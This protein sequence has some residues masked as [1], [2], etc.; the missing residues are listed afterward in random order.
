MAQSSK[1]NRYT[2]E[3]RRQMVERCVPGACLSYT[4]IRPKAEFS[5]EVHNLIYSHFAQRL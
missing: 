1:S 2:L 3:F 5:G 4:Q